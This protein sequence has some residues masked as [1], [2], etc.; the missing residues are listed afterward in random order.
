MFAIKEGNPET[1]AK[2]TVIDLK[3]FVN[4]ELPNQSIEQVMWLGRSIKSGKRHHKNDKKSPFTLVG[5]CMAHQKNIFLKYLILKCPKVE[6]AIKSAT[7]IAT[8]LG[9]SIAFQHAV[10]LKVN[11][12]WI[13]I[14]SP[15]G[16]QPKQYGI[17]MVWPSSGHIS[18]KLRESG[19]HHQVK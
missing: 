7:M 16:C 4:N 10:C 18:G 12:R 11:W 2:Q 5:W 1:D 13:L 17:P 15:F 3:Y 8:T 6:K 14:Q 9:Q 19:P